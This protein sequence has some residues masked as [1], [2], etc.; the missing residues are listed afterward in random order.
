MV[1]WKTLLSDH[2]CLPYASDLTDFDILTIGLVATMGHRTGTHSGVVSLD[3]LPGLVKLCTY[4]PT[5]YILTHIAQW[6][7]HLV[8]EANQGL[9]LD[10]RITANTFQTP[11]MQ[12]RLYLGGRNCVLLKALQN[13]GRE[14]QDIAAFMKGRWGF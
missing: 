2:D 11:E 9:Q 8:L 3:P 1:L 6:T 13:T 12:V 4:Y 5:A 10:L 7:F 14:P